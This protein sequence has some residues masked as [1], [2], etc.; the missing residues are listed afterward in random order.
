MAIVRVQT[1]HQYPALSG[2]SYAFGS[3]NTVGNL[4]VVCVTANYVSAYDAVVTDTQGNAYSSLTAA[5]GTLQSTAQIWYAPKCKAGANSVI[6]TFSKVNSVAIQAME[7]SGCKT[8]SPLDVAMTP[9]WALG[10]N[11]TSLQSNSF[12]PT[13]GSLIVM[14]YSNMY[15]DPGT[16][17]SNDGITVFE[18]DTSQY[19]LVGD[20]L[21]ASAG[22][23]TFTLS[24]ANNM[25]NIRYYA[26]VCACFLAAGGTTYVKSISETGSATD[27]LTEKAIAKISESESGSAADT[28]SFSQFLFPKSISEAGSASDSLSFTAFFF[29]KSIAETGSAS[30]NPTFSQF[31]FT[32]TISETG[33][34][35][36]SVSYSQFLYPVGIIEAGSA[37]DSPAEAAMASIT[38]SASASDT[39]IAYALSVISEAGS[40]TDSP[41]STYQLNLSVVETGSATD[42]PVSVAVASISESAA[43]SDTTYSYAVVLVTENGSASDD[44]EAYA[45]ATIIENASAS[46]ISNSLYQINASITESASADD[47]NYSSAIAE[48]FESGSAS[49]S[50]SATQTLLAFISESGSAFDYPSS[51]A[52]ANIS[53][54]GSAIDTFDVTQSILVS[55]FESGNAHDAYSTI[56]IEPTIYMW[57]GTL[58]DNNVSIKVWNGTLWQNGTIKVY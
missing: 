58:W 56:S 54:T 17:T 55:I 57:N 21:A 23:Q 35:A 31:V 7:Y 53:E 16:T 51:I 40:A 45:L 11:T 37:S 14:G 5:Y 44:N 26:L 52:V 24:F 18:Y 25:G 6:V 3:N 39:P 32:S 38:E 2:T 8:T 4:I 42:S 28:P 1:F 41:S 50:I 20:N 33:N 22:S 30:D 15:L 43:A 29:T 49:D 36:D 12:S 46:D 9:M 48:I 10:N 34:A 27:S 13:A 47:S 19:D